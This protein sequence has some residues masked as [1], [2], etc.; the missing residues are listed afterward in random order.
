MAHRLDTR[1][2][3]RLLDDDVLSVRQLEDAV[4]QQV[5]HGGALDTILLELGVVDEPTVSAALSLAWE[6]EPVSLETLEAPA[7]DAVARLPRRMA[8]TMGLCPLR[9]DDGGLHVAVAA[10]IDG[11]LLKEISG[12]VGAELAAHVVPEIRLH[13]AIARAYELPL[14]ERTAALLSTL[15]HGK[16]MPD[17]DIGAPDDGEADEPG[18]MMEGARK[19]DLVEALAHLAA[20][21][22]RDGISRVSVSYARR[23][24][25]FSAMFGVRQ[26]SAVGW[27]R[28]GHC[29]GA[30]FDHRPLDVPP[31]S[32]LEQVLDSPSPLVCRPP[33]TDGNST[34]FGWLGR[35]RPQTAVLIPI[36]V[37]RRTVAVLYGDGGVR[38]RG[39]DELSDLVAFG[40][41][42]GSAFETLLRQRHKENAEL[43]QRPEEEP[44]APPPESDMGADDPGGMPT[45]V[46]QPPPLD[47]DYYKQ[48]AGAFAPPPL[49]PDLDGGDEDLFDDDEPPPAPSY[50]DA[51]SLAAEPEFDDDFDERS[52]DNF[53]AY[54]AAPVAESAPDPLPALPD[55]EEVALDEPPAPPAVVGSAL[56]DDAPPP[57]MPVV[58]GEVVE[59][60]P[61]GEAWQGA[62]SD[63]VAR[64]HQGGE[65]SPDEPVLADPDDDDWEDV[66]LD[67]AN[68]RQLAAQ[69]DKPAQKPADSA[70][71]E[72]SGKSPPAP[73]PDGP[74][75]DDDD[76]AAE[77]LVKDLESLHTGTVSDAK[78]KLIA[79]GEEAVDAL[80][81]AFPGRLLT[82]PFAAK[83]PPDAAEELGPL[84]EVLA[85][86]GATG[87]DAAIPHLDSHYPAH[88]FC[89]TFLFAHSPDPRC[90]ELLRARLHDQEPRIRKLAAAALSHFVAHP[91]FEVVLTH[92]RKRLTSP[93]PEARQRAVWF[94]GYFRDVGAVPQ[95]IGLLDDHPEVARASRS[96]L[97]QVTLQDHGGDTRSWSKWWKRGRKRS[98]I[99][100]LIDGLRAKDRDLRYIASTELS[101]LSGDSFGYRCDDPKK[102]RDQAARV[103]ESWW[104]EERQ[105]LAQRGA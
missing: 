55:D 23:F 105:R 24:L 77:D 12:L 50:D 35:R 46:P 96:A 104:S 13:Q 4:Q 66:V 102:S 25:P 80:R 21:G 19:W 74:P 14:D 36:S 67:A 20:Q 3:R 54:D 52:V 63:T 64:G 5:V 99:D 93:A 83:H 16:R 92:L 7:P 103:F 8:A 97:R 72:M 100:W 38:K 26:G 45:A 17:I 60:A 44:P 42:V 29:E 68:A 1:L 40:A 28:V 37:A 90:V 33:I 84:I 48:S 81:T 76:D 91:G 30:Q 9:V 11:D 53:R 2:S 39:I 79:L 15:D 78:E 58:F 89:A 85:E 34:L 57:E 62:L 98:R 47:D 56:D 94:L 49:P 10:P 70:R 6:T 101:R 43:F 61:A 32:V 59:G 18:S 22:N 87:L 41:R 27:A 31:D 82:D 65:S 51:P 71:L 86:L 73:G 88:R 69:G 95:L 75:P